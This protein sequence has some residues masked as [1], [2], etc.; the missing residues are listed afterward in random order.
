MMEEIKIN[1]V[2]LVLTLVKEDIKRVF[3]PKT[4][5]LMEEVSI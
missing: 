3:K 2:T 4:H 1:R 5:D